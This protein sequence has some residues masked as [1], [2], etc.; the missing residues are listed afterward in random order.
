MPM[1]WRVKSVGLEEQLTVA[2]HSAP[3]R[4]GLSLGSEISGC[5]WS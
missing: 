2:G 4:G 3:I 1:R 5:D